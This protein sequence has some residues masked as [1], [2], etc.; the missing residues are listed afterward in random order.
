VAALIW[1]RKI[2]VVPKSQTRR[3]PQRAGPFGTQ[4][5]QLLHKVLPTSA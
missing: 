3:L 1:I 4:T 5:V 2:N